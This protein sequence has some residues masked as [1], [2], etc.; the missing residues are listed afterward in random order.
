MFRI[1]IEVV[2]AEVMR[3]ISAL[4]EEIQRAIDRDAIDPGEEARSRP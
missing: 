3:P 4:F 2:E 1:E